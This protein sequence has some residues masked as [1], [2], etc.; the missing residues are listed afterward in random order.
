MKVFFR[1]IWNHFSVWT[2]RTSSRIFGK[3]FGTLIK[4]DRRRRLFHGCI[5]SFFI[6]LHVTIANMLKLTHFDA[7]SRAF[8][9]RVAFGIANVDFEDERITY[10]E[11][12]T[13]RGE[14][15]SSTEVPLGGLPVLTLPNG[16]AI[17]Q[18]GAITRYAAKR[19]GLY[20]SDPEQSL[21][22]DEI[23]ECAAD[24]YTQAPQDKDD[25]VK[26]QKREEF[27]A[28][29]LKKLFNLFAQRL[30]GAGPYICGENLTIADIQLYGV[31]KAIR[32]GS[33]GTYF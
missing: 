3:I 27:A 29:Y 13:R 26:K 32:G 10:S 28:G 31:V 25:A 8:T 11:L 23:I 5:F 6:E 7:P 21:L 12:E 4:K 9:T 15:G 17:C 22:V 30:A 18:S 19:A 20:P 1:G 24:A 33:F 2:S 16:K 14:N